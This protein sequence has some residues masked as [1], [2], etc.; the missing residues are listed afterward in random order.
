MLISNA[1]L[2]TFSRSGVDFDRLPVETPTPPAQNTV[3]FFEQSGKSETINSTTFTTVA[4][5]SGLY[6]F[7]S[8]AA[9]TTTCSYLHNNR[10]ITVAL[11]VMRVLPGADTHECSCV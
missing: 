11:T 9:T 6:P 10:D 1:A 8:A 2:M 7:P 4:N 3:V 5:I